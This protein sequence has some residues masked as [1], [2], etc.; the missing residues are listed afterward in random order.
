MHIFKES[1]I[2]ITKTSS[3]PHPLFFRAKRG[4]IF[5]ESLS[6][7]CA[8][9]RQTHGG[10]DFGRRL[11]QTWPYYFLC[12]RPPDAEGREEGREAGQH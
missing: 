9:G 1:K 10:T 2:K 6:I 5:F 3:D 7:S 4:E 8:G 11:A 12:R